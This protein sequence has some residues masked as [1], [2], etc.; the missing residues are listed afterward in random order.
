M[1]K[2]L[3]DNFNVLLIYRA[4]IFVA[5]IVVLFQ[6]FCCLSVRYLK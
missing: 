1:V 5:V 3:Q 6:T 2:I 4:V